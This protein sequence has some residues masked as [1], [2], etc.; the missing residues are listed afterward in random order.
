[1]KEATIG[2]S[3]HDE[4]AEHKACDYIKIQDAKKGSKELACCISMRMSEGVT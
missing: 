4:K 1:M 2:T 3:K